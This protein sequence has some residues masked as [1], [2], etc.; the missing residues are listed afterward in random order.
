MEFLHD[1]MGIAHRDLKH[2]NILMGRKK[3]DPYNE[4][5]RQ[6]MIK[7]CDFT[8]AIILPKDEPDFKVSIDAGTPAFN[9]PEVA[10]T[11]EKLPK[12][13]DVWSFGITMYVYFTDNLPYP[14][15]GS[16]EQNIAN[17][18]YKKV[19][20]EMDCSDLLKDLLGSILDFDPVKR[21]SFKQILA[22]TWF[23]GRVEEVLDSVDEIFYDEEEKK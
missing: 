18:D 9:A 8:T 14:L 20:S 11:S 1:E 22:H 4:D 10:A 15:E 23:E 7:V 13:L 3:A 5:E 16:M 2:E 17:C 6:E 19:I 12:P 21:P